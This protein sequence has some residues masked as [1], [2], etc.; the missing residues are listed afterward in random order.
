MLHDGWVRG[1]AASW[2]APSNNIHMQQHKKQH[3]TIDARHNN[4]QHNT[5]NLPQT[6]NGNH[7]QLRA[8]PPEWV[9]SYAPLTLPDGAPAPLPAPGRAGYAM[10][11]NDNQVWV[12]DEEDG[13]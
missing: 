10:R 6:A 5:K 2:F 11:L 1:G 4:T 12:L 9:Y 13:V 7:L 3:T 8:N